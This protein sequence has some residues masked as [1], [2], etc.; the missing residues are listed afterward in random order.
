[1][2]YKDPEKAKQ[3]GKARAQKSRANKKL[4][5]LQGLGASVPA[6]GVGKAASKSSAGTTRLAVDLSGDIPDQ[7]EFAL[8]KVKMGLKWMEKSQD[9]LEKLP[10]VAYNMGRAGID[11]VNANLALVAPPKTD[12]PQA[13]SVA[14][15]D[16][17]FL[18]D[19][20]YRHLAEALLA[21]KCDLQLERERVAQAAE[22]SRRFKPFKA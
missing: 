21:R 13:G 15:L 14:A 2:P 22:E 6:A 4:R 11:L 17:E 1:M 16:G 19:D 5:A 9:L 10:A 12:G 3:A 20:E 8:I 18:A 7:A